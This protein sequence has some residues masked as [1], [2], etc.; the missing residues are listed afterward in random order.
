M[1]R[2]LGEKNY[3]FVEIVWENEPIHSLELARLAEE[4]LAW[5]KSTSYTVLRRLSQQGI[6]QNKQSMVS[7]LVTKE[8]IK[9]N[10]LNYLLN[11]MFDSSIF[12]LFS[13]LTGN[14]H[15]SKSEAQKLKALIDELESEE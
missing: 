11:K 2:I 10:E 8:D 4:K 9:Q 5:S 15:L 3:Q 14:K 12:S 7:S 13:S 6:L 1:I